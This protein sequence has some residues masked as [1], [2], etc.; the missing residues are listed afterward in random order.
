MRRKYWESKKYF[1]IVLSIAISIFISTTVVNA[2]QAPS[3]TSGTTIG[4]NISTTG[5][6]TVGG[7]IST[8]DAYQI[9]ST[10]VLIASSTTYNTFMGFGAGTNTAAGTGGTLSRGGLLSPTLIIPTDNTFLGYL[11]GQSN[12]TG[13]YNTAIGSQAIGQ[14]NTTGNYNTAIGYESMMSGSDGG[15]N[16]AVGILSLSVNTTGDY[17]VAMG[18][19]TLETNSSGSSNTASGSYALSSNTTGSSNTA[20]GLN[21]LYSVIT[22]SNNVG[23]G[24]NA[25]YY[26]GSTYNSN[27]GS[28]NTGVGVNTLQNGIYIASS[29]AVGYDAANG[30]PVGY[31][32][33]GGTYLGYKS[34]YNADTG[35]NYNTLLGYKSGYNITFGSNNIIIGANVNAPH[36]AA[37]PTNNQQLNIGN[38]LYG[39]GIYNG[40]TPSSAPVI[41]NIGIG[42]S[43][44]TVPLQ[45]T[46]AAA[47]ATTTV[48]FGKKGQTKGTCLKMY[49]DTGAVQ[50]VSIQSGSFVISATSCQ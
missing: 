6:L 49:D 31:V 9:G 21:A 4:A 22:G 45:V 14:S 44:P 1:L 12:T 41:G 3:S 28:A 40:L 24:A 47:N 5:L 18:V 25:L 39:N 11:S 34:G 15:N 33:V 38:L 10:N 17:N 32:N 35:S 20:D 29:T 7:L 50:Y 2:A 16:T 48:E 42:T 8:G 19:Q 37:N 26:S 36:V 46:T 30:N 13:S 43:T 27:G 23:I